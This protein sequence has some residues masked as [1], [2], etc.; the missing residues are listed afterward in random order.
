MSSTP[1]KNDETKQTWDCVNSPSMNQSDSKQKTQ[2]Y[3]RLVKTTDAIDLSSKKPRSIDQFSTRRATT[4]VLFISE[5]QNEEGKL[6]QIY[7][8]ILLPLF[9]IFL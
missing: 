1:D 2:E 6:K 3:A 8:S 5:N 7:C 4:D 9:L